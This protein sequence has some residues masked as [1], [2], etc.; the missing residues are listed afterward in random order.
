M[1]AQIPDSIADWSTTAG[2][3]QPSGS[4]NVGPDLDDNLRAMQAAVRQTYTRGS[5]A[6]AATCDIGTV[7]AELIT[8]T[9]TTTITSLGSTLGATGYGVHKLLT[10]AGALTLTHSASLACITSANLTTAAGDSCMVEYGA[11]GWTMLWYQRKSGNMISLPTL[12]SGQ[13]LTNNGTTLSWAPMSVSVSALTSA[14]GTGTLSNGGNALNW[15]WAFT[16]VGQTGLVIDGRGNYADTVLFGIDNR[17]NGSNVETTMRI[18]YGNSAGTHTVFAHYGN[19]FTLNAGSLGANGASSSISG[20]HGTGGSF[21]GGALLVTAG[22]GAGGGTGGSLWLGAG[23]GSVGGDVVLSLSALRVTS[24]G[25]T[26]S[27][28]SGSISGTNSIGRING[29][30]GTSI[31]LTFGKTLST[32]PMVLLTCTQAGVTLSYSASTSS[33]VITASSSL[34]GADIS[35]MCICL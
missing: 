16:A 31:T 33:V 28:S 9:G 6:S 19:S 4:A 10:F 17:I 35:Y 30:S 25:S 23:T 24:T 8:V 13:Y 12:S 26:P 29:A 7:D 5:I 14:T 27:T 22:N 3:N 34:S 15:A 20:A 11:S 18:R 32:T 1:P 21:D 2:S